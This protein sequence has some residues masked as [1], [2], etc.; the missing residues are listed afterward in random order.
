MAYKM[1][2]LSRIAL[3]LTLPFFAL[4][5]NKTDNCSKCHKDLDEANAQIVANYQFDIHFQKGFS[6]DACHGG[7]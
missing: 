6:C 7:D 1:R 3:S 2:I 4:A 5:E